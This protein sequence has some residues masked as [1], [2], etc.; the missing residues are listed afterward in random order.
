MKT[1]RKYLPWLE[2]ID[3]FE[4]GL[5]PEYFHAVDLLVKVTWNIWK[6]KTCEQLQKKVYLNEA[7]PTSA[8]ITMK[9]SIICSFI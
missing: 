2:V 3:K 8:Y 7:F 4:N 5:S 1:W 9:W 6:Y